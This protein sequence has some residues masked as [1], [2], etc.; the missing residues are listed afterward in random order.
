MEVIKNWKNPDSLKSGG[1]VVFKANLS[2][3]DPRRRL[4]EKCDGINLLEEDSTDTF[5]SWSREEV[6]IEGDNNYFILR[7]PGMPVLYRPLVPAVLG[8]DPVSISR[9]H[10]EDGIEI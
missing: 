7:D 1:A 3:W 6:E 8:D 4:D 9:S 5:P 10:R 2:L